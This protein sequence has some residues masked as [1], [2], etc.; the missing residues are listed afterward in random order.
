MFIPCECNIYVWNYSDTMNI[1]YVLR[2]LIKHLGLGLL[3]L[4]SLISA[5]EKFW[6]MQ[7]YQ[8]DSFNHIHIWQ[9]SSQLSC[10]DPVKYKRDIQWLMSMVSCQKGPTRHAY[11]WQIG[12]FWQ[13]TPD[14]C[15]HNAEKLGKEQNRGNWLNNPRPRALVATGLSTQYAALPS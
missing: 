5:Q 1:N 9:V 7:S 11:T 15:T 4:R 13:D 6:I 3:N 10:G 8:L 2:M 14:V 12:P